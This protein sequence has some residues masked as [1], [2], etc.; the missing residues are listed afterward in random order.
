MIKGKTFAKVF[1]TAHGQ[2]MARVG[3]NDDGDEVLITSMVF[4]GLEPQSAAKFK[5]D[6]MAWDALDKF[7]QAD[8]DRSA[9]SFADMID[10]IA[11][12]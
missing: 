3:Q 11:A 12:P 9:A 2:I 1:D 7:A 8:A 5:E 4:D 6:Q 10:R